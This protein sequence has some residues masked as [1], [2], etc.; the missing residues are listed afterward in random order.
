MLFSHCRLEVAVLLQRL[1]MLRILTRHQLLDP[2]SDITA[3]TVYM[4]SIGV[5]R[6][7]I[8]ITITFLDIIH[9]PVFYLKLNSTL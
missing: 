1:F 4:G 9:R 5:C 2:N 3:S 8:D 7:Y 6:R